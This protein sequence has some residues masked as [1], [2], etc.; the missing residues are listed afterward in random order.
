[1]D[2]N[3]VYECWISKCAIGSLREFTNV[4]SMKWRLI[5]RD[6][7]F[8]TSYLEDMKVMW[9]FDSNQESIS[10][11]KNRFYWDD[12]FSSM[13]KWSFSDTA[14]SR[15][16]WINIMG[17]PLLFWNDAFFLKVGQILG[18]P[19]VIE[20]NT[21][22]RNRLD[23]GRIMVLIPFGHHIP[24]KISVMEGVNMFSL[25]VEEDLTPVTRSR[26]DGFLGLTTTVSKEGGDVF[27]ALEKK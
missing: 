16:A 9:R 19:V 25:E 11:I 14:K 6:F 17:V 23:K 3:Q 13:G 2:R 4:S 8:S 5:S 24:N 21:K 26:L 1:M 12:C 10:F 20:G 22:Q 7:L 27:L 18:E 15:L